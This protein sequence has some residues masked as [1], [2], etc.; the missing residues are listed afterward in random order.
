MNTT[1]LRA[2]AEALRPMAAAPRFD[3]ID[4]DRA[5]DYLLACADEKPVEG[6]ASITTGSETAYWL[7]HLQAILDAIE[8]A[9]FV[10]MGNNNNNTDGF[11]LHPAPVAPQAEQK[12]KPNP[13]EVICPACTHQFRAIPVNVQAQLAQREPLSEKQIDAIHELWY[14]RAGMSFADVVRAVERAHG[15]IGGSDAD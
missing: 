6:A 14:E 2:L 9:G 1:E 13:D 12:R 10:L 3:G 7:L 5:A 8:R 15:I 4:I 11:W